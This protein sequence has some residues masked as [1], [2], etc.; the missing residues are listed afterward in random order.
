MARGVG[1]G[2]VGEKA[3]DGIRIFPPIA[4]VQ[5]LY[6]IS[7]YRIIVEICIEVLFKICVAV[8]EGL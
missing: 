4:L 2:T 5:K 1:V 6:S 3:I 7:C 8:R